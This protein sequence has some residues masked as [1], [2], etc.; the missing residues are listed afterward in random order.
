MEIRIAFYIL[1]VV[2]F[3]SCQNCIPCNI[4]CYQSF[5]TKGSDTKIF[6]YCAFSLVQDSVI[7]Y[8]SK[9]YQCDSIR[10]AE[11]NRGTAC[12]KEINQW[13]CK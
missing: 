7:V 5:C 13:G 8:Q 3:V 9:G 2:N 10:S 4:D 6:D 12:G 1:C 11:T